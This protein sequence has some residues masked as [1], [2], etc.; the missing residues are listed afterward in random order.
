MLKLLQR[1]GVQLQSLFQGENEAEWGKL[2]RFI[3]PRD[4]A[5]CSVMPR[6]ANTSI[7]KKTLESRRD[8]S[9]RVN[10]D[11]RQLAD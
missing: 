10:W 4:G 5:K 11:F 9:E 3:T 2:L 6:E 8:E 1:F 7:T